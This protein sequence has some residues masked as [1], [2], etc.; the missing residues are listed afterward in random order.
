ME[1][2]NNK[3]TFVMLWRKLEDTR[4]LFENKHKIFCIRRVLQSW[5]PDGIPALTTMVVSK[6]VKPH[7]IG[8]NDAIWLICAES[9]QYGYDLLPHPDLYPRNSREFLQA[10]VGVYLGIGMKGVN[11]KA[12]DD[13]YSVVFPNSTPID[14]AK[15]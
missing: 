13:A 8:L 7:G 15:K 5:I 3:E 14:F 1:I 9:E 12:L 4:I 11:L 6:K 10:F 2:K